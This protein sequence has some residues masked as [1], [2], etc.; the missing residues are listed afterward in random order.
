MTKDQTIQVIQACGY[1]YPYVDFS[2]DSDEILIDF[3]TASD[4]SAAVERFVKQGI[5]GEN[6]RMALIVRADSEPIT[7][8]V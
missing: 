4:P 1:K 8:A 2:I 6:I 5:P 7:T 3:A